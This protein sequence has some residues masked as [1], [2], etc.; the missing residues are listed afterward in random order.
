MLYLISKGE[1]LF[2]EGIYPHWKKKKD[3]TPGYRLNDEMSQILT[4]PNLRKRK[5][6]KHAAVWHNRISKQTFLCISSF[7]C[8]F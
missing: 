4:L 3:E 5:P 2:L 1:A 7:M 8:L 6:Y